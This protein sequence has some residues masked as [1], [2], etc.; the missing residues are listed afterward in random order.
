MHVYKLITCIIVIHL[1]ATERT[2]VTYLNFLIFFC[3]ESVSDCIPEVITLYLL[4]NAEHEVEI[5]TPGK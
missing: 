4:C 2:D 5:S 1:P 3:L